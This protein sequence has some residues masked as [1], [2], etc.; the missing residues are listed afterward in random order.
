M[1]Q[2]IGGYKEDFET[3]NDENKFTFVEISVTVRKLESP[4]Q[5]V[6]R[7]EFAK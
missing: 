7:N 4:F 2:Q 1:L 5:I 3:N 6:L